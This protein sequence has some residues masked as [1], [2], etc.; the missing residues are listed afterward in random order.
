MA[1][2]VQRSSADRPHAVVIGAGFAGLECVKALTKADA[3]VDVTVVDRQNFHTFSALL[4]QVA[5]AALSPADVVFPVRGVFRGDGDVRVLKADVTA[6]DLPGRRVTLDDGSDLAYDH[7]VVAAGATT[8]WFGVPGADR[9]GLPLY[10]LGD[11]V[12]LRNHLLGRFE[13]ADAGRM[14]TAPALSVVVVGGG[15]TGVETAGAIMELFGG[16]LARDFPRLDV[17]AARVVL[18]EM[19]DRLLAGFSR[20]ASRHAEEQLRRR[21]VDVRLG[22]TVAA[23]EDGRVVLSSGESVPAGTLVWAG[24][25]RGSDLAESLGVERTKSGRVVVDEHL[26]VPGHPEVYVVGD[27]AAARRKGDL[28]PQVAPVAQQEGRYAGRAIARVV[29]G[30]RIRPFRYR[31]LGSM[32]TIGRGAAVADL[33][34][35]IHLT[36]FVGWLAWLGL[37]LVHLVGVR[38]RISVFVNWAWSYLTWD[39][40]PRLIL[41]PAPGTPD[42][43]VGPPGEQP[44]PG[45]P[46]AR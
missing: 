10:R 41:E 38:N 30:G 15:P 11:A 8:N 1:V 7:L 35:G 26:R 20:T 40:G 22:A 27:L 21:G 39:R 24:G 31:D 37:H 29:A 32:A 5:T 46:P 2:S 18:V 45:P 19:G 42:E 25:V 23:V 34:L 28:L 36:G 3:G 33:P 13:A 9:R 44:E 17:G 6:V 43:P 12:R 14:A 16:V 4:Y